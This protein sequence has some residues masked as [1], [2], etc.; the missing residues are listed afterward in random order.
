MQCP[1][2]NCELPEHAKFCQNCGEKIPVSDEIYSK[3]ISESKE[4]DTGSHPVSQKEHLK[5]SKHTADV[6]SIPNKKKKK[7]KFLKILGITFCIPIIVFIC[8]FAVVFG[9]AIVEYS[10]EAEFASS[11]SQAIEPTD[12]IVRSYALKAIPASHDGEYSVQQLCDIYNKLY[13][14]WVHV[15]DPDGEEYIVPASESVKVLRGDC[16]DYAVLMASLVEA[17]GGTSRV[18][19]ASDSAGDE[20]VYA[21]VYLNDF[22][23]G[24]D[25]VIDTI[26]RKYGVKTV[27]YHIDENGDYWLNLDYTSYYPGSKYYNSVGNEFVIWSDGQYAIFD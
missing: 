14:D 9:I 17:I 8:L 23:E 24:Q 20:H 15:N 12:P 11:Y 18:I 21:E 4:F 25:N 6:S 10:Q 27:Y 22:K 13:N 2:C 19:V 1:F 3:H 5:T 26:G 7:G 16:D